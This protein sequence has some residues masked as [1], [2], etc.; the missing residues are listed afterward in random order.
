MPIYSPQSVN[1]AK[2]HSNDTTK[3]S[4]GTKIK[5]QISCVKWS[6]LKNTSRPYLSVTDFCIRLLNRIT[7]QSVRRIIKLITIVTPY[8]QATLI[9]QVSIIF[10]HSFPVTTKHSAVYNTHIIFQ[11][12]GV[13][14]QLT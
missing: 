1:T 12:T 14:T 2:T 5:N 4:I 7:K 9:K 8:T 13:L 10:P 3:L 11:H 6:F